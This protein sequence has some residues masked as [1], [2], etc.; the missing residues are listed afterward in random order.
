M[1][2]QSQEK[3][4]E[5]VLKNPDILGLEEIAFLKARKS[6]LSDEEIEKFSGILEETEEEKSLID[7]TKAELLAMCQEKGFKIPKIVPNKAGLVEL[8]EAV[9]AE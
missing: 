4:A 8:L 3:L 1:D 9:P 7:H 5:I 2:R 6:Y